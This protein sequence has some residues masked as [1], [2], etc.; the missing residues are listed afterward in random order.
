MIL[1]RF[2]II[3]LNKPVS[4]LHQVNKNIYYLNNL[5]EEKMR[6]LSQ[7]NNIK[8]LWKELELCLLLLSITEYKFVL[9]IVSLVYKN[10]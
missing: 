1:Y 5:I 6:K 4:H 2:L 7:N 8:H 10:I 9:F 3:L